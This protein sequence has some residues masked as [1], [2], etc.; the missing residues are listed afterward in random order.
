[1]GRD[2]DEVAECN[3]KRGILEYGDASTDILRN[4]LLVVVEG[5]TG[6]TVQR[7]TLPFLRPLLV[8]AIFFRPD[9]LILKHLEFCTL[10]LQSNA[11]KQGPSFRL[12]KAEGWRKKQQSHG[13]NP[14]FS[15]HRSC[16]DFAGYS[17]F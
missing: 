16:I 10:Q 8:R 4:L 5:V 9:L 13:R 15:A 3:R 14:F 1:M 6:E 17:N 7:K 11:D 12:L 2:G